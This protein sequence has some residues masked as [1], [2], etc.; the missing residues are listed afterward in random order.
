MFKKFTQSPFRA[1]WMLNLYPPL[2]VNRVV[3]K[4]IS[5]NYR[6]VE[7]VIKKSFLNRNIQ[8][9]IFGG[10]IFSA[11]DPFFALMYWQTFLQMGVKTEVWLKSAHIR[12]IKPGSTD[13]NLTFQLSEEDISTAY[14]ELIKTG[15]I[16]RT[17]VVQVRNIHNELC[18]E[19]DMIA[20]L[21]I[22]KTKNAEGKS[23]F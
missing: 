4:H 18:A 9:T 17:H 12:Y 20:Y 22:P 16:E 19:I 3:V 11:A 2:L 15:K 6:R 1:K 14:N 23:V 21:R 13:L 8:G 10:T 7:V 5:K